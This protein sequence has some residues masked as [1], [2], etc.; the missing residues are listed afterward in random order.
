MQQP[1]ADDRI[2]CDQISRGFKYHDP[3][4]RR[5]Y[6]I[7]RDGAEMDTGWSGDFL[8]RVS[9]IEET[10][11]EASDDH[12]V[13]NTTARHEK[14]LLESLL[15]NGRFEIGHGANAEFIDSQTTDLTEL[16]E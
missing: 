10:V 13:R 5:Y 3:D 11:A 2:E 15:N 12:A 6:V 4:S 9:R 14:E 7:L 8:V 1:K 16:S